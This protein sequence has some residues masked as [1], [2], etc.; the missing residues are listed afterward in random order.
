MALD[1]RKVPR[2]RRLPTSDL[3]PDELV[4]IRSLMDVAFGDDE[5]ERFTDEDWHHALGGVHV[6]L[7]L[8]GAIVSHAAVV[9]REIHVGTEV[10]RT[11]YVEAVA[12]APA[13]QGRGYGSTVIDAINGLIRAEFE[14]GMLGTGR[15]AFYERLGW[16]TWRGPAFVRTTTGL[17]RTPDEEGFLLVL[18]TPTSPLLDLDASISCESRPGDVW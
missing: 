3:R 16:R 17:R 11:G 8:Q 14:L 12:T 18:E 6:V 10:L 9:E 5:D 7:D 15:H 2:V 4:A 13:H 1:D